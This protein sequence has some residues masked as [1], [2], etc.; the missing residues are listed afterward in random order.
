MQRISFQTIAGVKRGLPGALPNGSLSE[1]TEVIADWALIGKSILS[2]VS[3][4][5][6]LFCEDVFDTSVHYGVKHNW[7]LCFYV[8]CF[9]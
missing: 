3:V 4:F 1:R 8:K 5:F 9:G 2:G 7:K 6:G